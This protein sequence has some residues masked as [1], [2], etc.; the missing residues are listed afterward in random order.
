MFSWGFLL[1]AIE[2]IREELTA[3]GMKSMWQN[4]LRTDSTG[5]PKLN[6]SLASTCFLMTV[7]KWA[8]FFVYEAEPRSCNL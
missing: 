1:L 6:M 8:E 5:R 3:W 7:A 4:S 2:A